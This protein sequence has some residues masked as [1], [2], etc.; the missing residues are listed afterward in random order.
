MSRVPR[1]VEEVKTRVTTLRTQYSK[2]LKCKPSG[3][4]NKTLTSRQTWLL[5]SLTFL[6]KHV[7]QRPTE[8]SLPQSVKEALAT[9]EHTSGPDDEAGLSGDVTAEVPASGCQTHCPQNDGDDDNEDDDSST[10]TPSTQCKRRKK[11]QS[12]DAIEQQKVKLLQQMCDA[13]D[14]SRSKPADADTTFGA[15]VTQELKAITNAPIKTRVKRQ[16]MNALYEAQELD[17][18]STLPP[19]F[20]P[21]S[22]SHR[23]PAPPYTQPPPHVTA[24][25]PYHPVAQP[26]HPPLQSHHSAAQLQ[27]PLVQPHRPPGQPPHPPGQPHHSTVEPHVQCTLPPAQQ[28]GFLALLDDDDHS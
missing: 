3:S 5:K 26:H 25:H 7:S 27:Y 14:A 17:Q 11:S 1:A 22:V 6:K 19:L 10:V 15:Q 16:I 12:G 20:P 18:S 21:P 23:Q 28:S 13:V 4:A 24:A 8:S 9:E 2:L